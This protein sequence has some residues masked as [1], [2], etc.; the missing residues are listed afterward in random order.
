MIHF[1][2]ST[3]VH[4]LSAPL[5]Q[6]TPPPSVPLS[7]SCPSIMRRDLLDPQ[8]DRAKHKVCICDLSTHRYHPIAVPVRAILVHDTGEEIKL[9]SNCRPVLLQLRARIEWTGHFSL[10][11]TAEML[12][13]A[14]GKPLIAER[15]QDG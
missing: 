7:D 6:A 15:D 3:N 2:S 10:T 8:Q 5:H 13:A 12:L 4:I 11:G 14:G 1:K 9:L